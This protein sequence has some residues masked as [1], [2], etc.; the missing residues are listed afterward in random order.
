MMKR[1]DQMMIG[2]NASL[3][4]IAIAKILSTEKITNT[5]KSHGPNARPRT[6]QRPKEP[7]R[8][9]RTMMEKA[10]PTNLLSLTT[11]IATK[12]TL[13]VLKKAKMLG[14]LVKVMMIEYVQN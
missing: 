1:T 4:L 10:I 6:R 3:A 9:T 12:R 7:K 2:Q 11:M 13:A 8:E 14:L 5:R